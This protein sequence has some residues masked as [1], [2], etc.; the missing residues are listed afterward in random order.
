LVSG[1][2]EL[3]TAELFEVEDARQYPPAASLC[4]QVCLLMRQRVFII[5]FA[6]KRLKAGLDNF[7]P[8]HSPV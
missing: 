7:G 3:G 8:A 2:A 4:L 1:I 5:A 6:A